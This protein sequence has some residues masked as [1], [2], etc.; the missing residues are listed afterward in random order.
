MTTSTGQFSKSSLS[1]RMLIGAAIGLVVI[2]YFVLSANGGNPEWGRFWMIRP[3]LVVPFAGA[4]G[5]LV[6]YFMAQLADINGWNK[7][8]VTVFSA[9]IFIIGLWM[10]IVL[11]LDGTM[12]H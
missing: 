6:S 8:L 12:W 5:G 1:K 9:I 7:I 10:G 2:S 11:G 3:L 4:I